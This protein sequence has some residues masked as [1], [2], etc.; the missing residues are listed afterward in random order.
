MSDQR[1]LTIPTFSIMLEHHT[2]M[3]DVIREMDEEG[4]PYIREAR[5]INRLHRHMQNVGK[6]KHKQLSTAFS[7]ENLLAAHILVDKDEFGGESRLIFDRS[8]IGVFRLF[9]RSLFQ[10]LTDVALK[11]QL[12]GVRLLLSQLES[13]SLL[14]SDADLD[15]KELM[16]EL[17]HRLSELL[18]SIRLNLVKMQDINQELTDASEHAAKTDNPQIFALL[19]QELIGKISRLLSRHILPTRQFLDEKSRLQDGRNLFECLQMFRRLFERHQDHQRALAMLRYEI[20]FNSFHSQMSKVSHSVDQFLARSKKRLRQFNAIEAAF[21]ELTCALDATQQNLKRSLIDSEFARNNS[22]FMGL[23]QQARPKVLRISRSE[24][25]L[26]NVISDIEARVADLGVLKQ[27]RYAQLVSSKDDS[28]ERR[29]ARAEQIFDLVKQMKMA[30]YQDLTLALHRR[31][32]DN[33]TDYHFID[34]LEGLNFLLCN[35]DMLDGHKLKT[36]N[37][38]N[39]LAQDE[40]IYLYRKIRTERVIL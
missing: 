19:Q 18:N 37:M 33:I 2:I 28:T 21:G 34:L 29:L 7:T 11:V 17:F 14:F 6:D 9:D 39:R 40:I 13:E 26:N 12:G 10:D 30:E 20:T 3:R 32:S 8:V 4:E 35:H 22:S 25:Y 15:Y 5:F 31:L 38:R 24:A 23:M 27:H 36:T 1:L 16:D